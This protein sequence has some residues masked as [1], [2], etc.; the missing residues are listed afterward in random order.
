[1]RNSSEVSEEECD[2]VERLLSKGVQP[3]DLNKGLESFFSASE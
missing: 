2:L 1:L 3:S